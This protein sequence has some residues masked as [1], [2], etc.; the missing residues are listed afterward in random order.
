MST[1]RKRIDAKAKTLL[2]SDEQF[3]IFEE[4]WNQRKHA[5]S[6][7]TM[8]SCPI[9]RDFS[10]CLVPFHGCSTHRVCKSCLQHAKDSDVHSCALCP[11]PDAT[12]HLQCPS[13]K[14]IGFYESVA[15]AEGAVCN[16]CSLRFVPQLLR[17]FKRA[18]HTYTNFVTH[19]EVVELR[20]EFHESGG[21]VRCPSCRQPLERAF[22]CNELF[23]CGHERV[24]AACGCFSFRWEAGLVQHRRER[25]CVSMPEEGHD[26]HVCV[27]E[28]LRESFRNDGIELQD[29]N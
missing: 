25:G 26:E 28:R 8:L 19:K 22:A 3:Y 20:Q 24:C 14:H 29:S 18:P 5:S 9:C 15:A 7:A 13:C 23:H 6:P 4:A 10:S 11:V 1:W 16:S 17:T 2:I 27:R 12:L 21:R